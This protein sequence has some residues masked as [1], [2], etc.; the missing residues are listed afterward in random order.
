MEKLFQISY[1]NA[2]TNY[3]GRLPIV[4][5]NGK[6]ESRVVCVAILSSNISL[7]IAI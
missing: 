6:F 1:E 2:L 5:E 4:A 7:V 3:G